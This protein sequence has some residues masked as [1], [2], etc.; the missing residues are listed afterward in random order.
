MS[1]S[2]QQ[3][4]PPPLLAKP[5]KLVLGLLLLASGPLIILSVAVLE[6]ID[7]ESQ[8]WG[9]A[10]FAPDGR[11]PWPG[12]H[13]IHVR[14]VPLRHFSNQQAMYE[15]VRDAVP[16]EE[17]EAIGLDMTERVISI[18]MP[19]G[20]MEPLLESGRAPW[21][22]EPELVAGVYT[23]LDRFELDGTTFQVVGRLQPG[24]PGLY[25]AYLLPAEPVWNPIFAGSEEATTGWLDPGGAERISKMEDPEAFLEQEKVVALQA[26]ARTAYALVVILGLLFV[27]IGGALAHVALFRRWARVRAGVFSPMFTAV[28]QHRRLVLGMHVLLFGSFFLSMFMSMRYP[29]ISIFLQKYIAHEF[30]EGGLSY[31]GA[32]YESGDIFLAA[33]ATF[34][35]NYLLQTVLLTVIISFV[36]PMIGVLKTL[37]S[38]VLAGFGMAPLWAGMSAMFVF[39]SITMTL[40]LEGYIFACVAVCA[41]WIHIQEGMRQR[42][43][44]EGFLAGI[45]VVGSGTLLSGVMLAL[46]GLY[47]ATTLILLM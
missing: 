28:A 39:H 13:I 17:A 23:R 18:D 4:T 43:L 20:E 36:V 33:G 27:A 40:E 32:A 26:P 10:V 46:A 5:Y 42:Q 9:S 14:H 29:F 34:L 21:P 12:T 47:E 1:L 2:L 41:F 35:N 11:P 45:K 37:A 22:G 30:S 44:K 3:S 19:S 31:I 16:R 24:I 8:T 38:F 15:Q 25:F 7:R 6:G